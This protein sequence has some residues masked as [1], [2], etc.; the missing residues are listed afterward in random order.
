MIHINYMFSSVSVAVTRGR[1]LYL[2]PRSKNI[3]SGHEKS[4]VYLQILP[5]CLLK[6]GGS[7]YLLF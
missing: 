1:G 7:D 4:V 5:K 3:F 6:T 2:F